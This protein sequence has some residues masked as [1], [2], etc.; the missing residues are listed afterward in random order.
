[1]GGAIMGDREVPS[2]FPAVV[3]SLLSVYSSETPDENKKKMAEQV[4][5][6]AT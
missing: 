3:A 5:W 6:V 1:M 2:N 4:S